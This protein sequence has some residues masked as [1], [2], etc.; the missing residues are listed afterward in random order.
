MVANITRVCGDGPG[1][2]RDHDNA[3]VALIRQMRADCT[4]YVQRRIE[5]PADGPPPLGFADAQDA[6][7]LLWVSFSSHSGVIHQDMDAAEC[8]HRGLHKACSIFRVTQIALDSNTPDT[9][10]A[11]LLATLVDSRTESSNNDRDACFA[12]QACGRKPYAV[13]TSSPR[14][15]GHLVRQ[16]FHLGFHLTSPFFLC[17]I[18]PGFFGSSG[19]R[20]RHV[21]VGF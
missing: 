1:N 6:T 10:L 12:K 17:S 18:A 4:R 11:K 14:Y 15:Y 8:V 13:L 20:T 16:R 7:R 2:G 5:V 3:T 9:R 19:L 21:P